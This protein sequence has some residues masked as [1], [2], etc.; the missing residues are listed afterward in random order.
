MA[1]L[2]V[3][4]SIY[5]LIKRFTPADRVCSFTLSVCVCVCVCVCLLYII[6]DRFA[7]GINTTAANTLSSTSDTAADN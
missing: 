7:G 6:T 4:I 2:H 3:N 5:E 1:A